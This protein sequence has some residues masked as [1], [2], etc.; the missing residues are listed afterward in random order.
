MLINSNE[1]MY[2]RQNLFKAHTTVVTLCIS[3]SNNLSLNNLIFCMMVVL[4]SFCL[5]HE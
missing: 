2:N 4:F 1:H 3:N 5:E